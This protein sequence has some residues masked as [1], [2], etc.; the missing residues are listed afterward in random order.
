MQIEEPKPNG[1]A[2]KGEPP[3]KKMPVFFIDEAH[4]L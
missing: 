4:K 3:A 1:D 2:N